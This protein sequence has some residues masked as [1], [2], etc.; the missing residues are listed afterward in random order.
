MWKCKVKTVPLKKS[1]EIRNDCFF[2]T[3]TYT[4][5]LGHWINLL[6]LNSIVAHAHMHTCIR[7]YMCEFAQVV[8]LSFLFSACDVK[9]RCVSLCKPEMWKILSIVCVETRL[10]LSDFCPIVWSVLFDN[11]NPNL[12]QFIFVCVCVRL[13][14]SST[15]LARTTSWCSHFLIHSFI[16]S[17]FWVVLFTFHFVLCSFS[18]WTRSQSYTF[19]CI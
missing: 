11:N 9:F 3:V 2:V 6:C 13:C 4:L 17:C 14:I 12:S 16:H 15:F 1:V 5:G 18:C 7:K 10:M 8:S 19:I